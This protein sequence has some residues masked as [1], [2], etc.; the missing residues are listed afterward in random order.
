[1][2]KIW[3][4]R[5]APNVAKV[6]WTCAELGLDYE[7]IPTGGP[8]GG[9]DE[10]A[11]RRLNP[12][13]R[14]PTLDDD[15]FILW[16]SHAIMRYLVRRERA[17]SFYPSKAQPVARIDQWLDWQ[18]A[19]LAEAVRDLVRLTIK[20]TTPPPAGQLTRAE[21]QADGLFGIVDRAL[22]ASPYIAGADFTLADI[23]IGVAVR[24]WTTLPVARPPLPALDSWAD[25][26]LNRPAAAILSA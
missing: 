10:P 22:R 13:G 6:L 14:I 12:N 9:V 15:G 24:R 26:V 18:S 23:P 11:Y 3:G 7:L 2:L 4:H 17:E 21:A 16:E 25:D 20:A 8:N 1:M 5:A 19:H